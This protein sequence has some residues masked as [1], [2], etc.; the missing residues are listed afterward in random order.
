MNTKLES[1]IPKESEEIT[2]MKCQLRSLVEERQRHIEEAK[3]LEF[4]IQ[5]MVAAL[6]DKC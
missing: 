1:E 2:R 5:K 6:V 3:S 4:E